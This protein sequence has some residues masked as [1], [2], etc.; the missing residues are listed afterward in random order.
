MSRRTEICDI[1]LDDELDFENEQRD[2]IFSDLSFAL[3]EEKRLL[4]RFYDFCEEYTTFDYDESGI[5]FDEAKEFNRKANKIRDLIL[6][7]IEAKLLCKLDNIDSNTEKK[8]ITAN[9]KINE[10]KYHAIIE[11]MNDSF[12]LELQ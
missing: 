5:N 7:N 12:N 11:V 1:E 6:S 3:Q 9:C 8:T 4:K 2:E 10:N